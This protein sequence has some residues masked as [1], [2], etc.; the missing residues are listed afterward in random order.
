M[1]RET[2]EIEELPIH[3]VEG[4]KEGV[5]SLMG[6]SFLAWMDGCVDGQGHFCRHGM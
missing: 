5:H 3:Q 4:V 2:G 1:T 6:P